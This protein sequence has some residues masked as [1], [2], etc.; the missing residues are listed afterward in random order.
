VGTIPDRGNYGVHLKSDGTRIGELDEEMVFE[1]RVGENIIL[2]AT[3][4]H[5][6]EI[7]RDRVVVS[8]A[9][10]E[11]GKPPFW[12]GERPGRPIELGRALGKFTR[13]LGGISRDARV[14]WLMKHTRLD[15]F[16]AENLANHIDDQLAHTG[17]LPT[18]QTIIVERFRDELGDWRICILSPFGARIHGPWAITLQ[19][20]FSIQTGFDVQI[21]YT[22]DG[23]VMRFA[24][25]EDEFPI[26]TLLPDLDAIKNLITEQVASTSL[27]AGLFRENAARA[28]LLPRQG[29]RQRKPLWAQRLKAQ[30][31]LAAVNDFPKFPIVLETYRQALSD[32]FDLDNFRNLLKD[33]HSRKVRVHDVET[34][35]ASPFARSLVFAYVA[36]YIYEQDAPLAERKAQALTLDRHMLTEL[37]GQVEL[38]DLIDLHVLR[39]F[40]EQL[41]HLTDEY[42][43]RDADEVHDLLRM[44][45]DLTED[46]IAERAHTDPAKWLADLEKEHRAVCI[47]LMGNRRW[48]AAEDAALYR[49][50]LGAMPPPELPSTFLQSTEHPLERLLQ[51]YARR[52]GPFVIHDLMKRYG[53]HPLQLEHVLSALERDGTLFHGEI[54]PG[55]TQP[56]WCH[57][58]VLH[59]L[60]QRTLAKYRNQAAPVDEAEFCMFLP[61]WHGIQ[62]GRTGMEHLLEVIQQLEDMPFS[63]MMLSQVILPQR[64]ADFHPDMLNELSTSGRIV[65]VGRSSLGINDG[66]I[67]LYRREQA[68]ILVQ[69][70]NDYT[71]PHQL[72]SLILTH[73]Q[74]NGASFLFEMEESVFQSRKD[75]TK[76]EFKDALWDLVWSG[77]ITND[78]F[79]PLLEIWRDDSLKHRKWRHSGRVSPE[80]RW[81]LVANLTGKKITDTER[82]L[83]RTHIFLERYGIVSREVSRAEDLQG[84]FGPVYKALQAME[85]AGKVRRGYFTEGLSGAQFGYIGAI[86][87]LR[88]NTAREKN[89]EIQEEDVLVLAAV[90][91]ANPYGALFPWPQPRKSESPSPRRIPHAW[92]ILVKGKPTLYVGPTGRQLITFSTQQY[93]E[94]RQLK[95]AFAALRHLPKGRLRGEIVVETVDGI[96]VSESPYYDLMLSCGFKNDYKG[97]SLSCSP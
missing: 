45:G 91:P 41:Q 80:G 52:H 90:D 48:I 8:P 76:R 60:K 13:R 75:C 55:G 38:R 61:Q 19:R 29:P 18:D 46:E 66:C 39:E 71:P 37:L 89:G 54:R 11:P 92:V 50:G 85:Q 12:K 97:V 44:L 27:F 31:L 87:R 86:E 47:D 7:T 73:L 51:R 43:A 96:P 77:L 1:T 88:G 57:V 14:P 68:S 16:A 84:G 81:S 4:W 79:T 93:E 94:Q 22:D 10:G 56:E 62:S 32:I 33:I 53:L 21:M 6:E 95:A 64:I 15:E 49:D 82:V 69:P 34:R 65:W 28:L 83:T 5:V 59:Q 26:E 25:T 58:K 74:H 63:W 9:P 40:E 17:A 42:R 24:G 3:T 30:N 36:E 2:G 78:T 67:A 70:D 72:H 23:I 20:F 35:S